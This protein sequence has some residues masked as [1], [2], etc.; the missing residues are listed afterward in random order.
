MVQAINRDNFSGRQAVT[1][2]TCHR[3]RLTPV[4]DAEARRVL[5]RGHHRN[6]MTPCS[7][8]AGCSDAHAGDS[9]SI[10]RRS[11]APRKRRRI[12][13]IAATGKVE[14]F[15]SFGGG[16]NFEYF[17]QAPDKRAMLSHL[18]DG[19]SSRTFDG[20]YR[21]VCDPAGGRAQVPVD[22][23][24]ARRRA[25][26]CAVVLSRADRAARDGAART[27][28]STEVDGKEVYP[29]PGKRRERVVREPLLRP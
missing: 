7:K 13:S 22:R 19:E 17:A 6:W 10:C 26:G 18:P 15:G 27:A 21:L 11:A 20:R 24:R 23:R 29:P 2:W 5:R 3:L 28:P 14:A 25:A 12:T 16:G 8:A 1:C 4:R 9:T